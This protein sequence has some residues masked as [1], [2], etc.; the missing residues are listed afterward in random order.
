MRVR[1]AHHLGRQADFL[2]EIGVS[3]CLEHGGELHK[4][5]KRKTRRPF[6][7]KRAMHVVMRSTRARKEW[8]LL[9]PNHKRRVDRIV[10]RAAEKHQITLYRFANVGNHLHFL[11][12][13]KRRVS[14]RAFIREVSGSIAFQIT[15]S[16]KSCP[17]TGKFWDLLPY[18]RV[19]SWGID[20]KTATRYLIANLIE[21]AGLWSRKRDPHLK[22]ILI[23][24]NMGKRDGPR[25][26]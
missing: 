13:A 6:D 10:R 23:S 19:V 1:H 4:K 5:G 12:R 22:L 14:F 25:A 8:S 24:A 16:K 3:T 11:F 21:S 9:H 18:S 17:L 20:F 15:G 2:K 26:G 7:P